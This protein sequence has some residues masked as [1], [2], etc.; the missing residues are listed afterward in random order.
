MNSNPIQDYW[1]LTK[2]RLVFLALLAV[3]LGVFMGSAGDIDFRFVCMILLG[4]GLVAAGSQAL[5]QWMERA[6]D[7]KMSRTMS[8]PI[9][10]GRLKPVHAFLFGMII[11]VAGLFIIF[12]TTNFLCFILTA[13]TLISYLLIYTPL[14]HVTPLCTYIGAVPGAL[15]PLIGWSA[16][17]GTLSPES[18]I[19]FAIL[20][21]WQLPHFFALSW[22]Y[23]EDYKAAQFRMLAVEDSNGHKIGSH[24]LFFAIALWGVSLFPT[25][26]GLTSTVYLWCALILG[27]SFT[28]FAILSMKQLNKKAKMLFRLSNIYLLFLMIIMVVDKV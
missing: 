15:P 26:F 9:P 12:K 16:V 27:L 2:P 11:S 23:R 20:F 6:D 10:A 8:R 13:G 21:I 19:L 17:T 18:W 1:Q 5:N 25:L 24:I 3:L 14:K 28:L 4:A 22:T 7:A